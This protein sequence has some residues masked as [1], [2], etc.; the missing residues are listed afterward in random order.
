[1]VT[2]NAS[3]DPISNRYVCVALKASIE[4]LCDLVKGSCELKNQGTRTSDTTY[5]FKNHRMLGERT[6]ENKGKKCD[7]PPS[8][9]RGLVGRNKVTTRDWGWGSIVDD[10]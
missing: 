9:L 8:V 10:M 3:K 1:M 5:M 2:N 4:T 7:T 6:S